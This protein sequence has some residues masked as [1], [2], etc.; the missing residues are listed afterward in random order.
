MKVSFKENNNSGKNPSKRFVPPAIPLERPEVKTFKKTDCLTLKLKSDPTNNDSQTTYELTIKFFNTGTPE[1]WLIFMRDF[2]RVLVGQNI[3]DGPAKYAMIRRLI[4][5][6]TLAVFNKAATTQGAENNAN[7]E[8]VMQAVTAH[9]F[10]Q[11][12]LNYQKRYM[13][14]FMRKPKTMSIREF[15]ARVAEM[16][17]YLTEFPPFEADQELSGEEIIDILEFA[18]PNSWQKNMVLQGFEPLDHTT[19]EFVSFCERNEF[20]EGTLDNSDSHG[21]KGKANSKNSPNDGKPR[22]KSSS[23]VTSKSNLKKRERNEKWC[24]LHQTNGHD[25]SECKVVQAQIKKMRQS[26]ESAESKTNKGNSYKKNDKTKDKNELMALVKESIKSFIKNKKQKTEKSFT[27][28]QDEEEEESDFNI[29]DI[30]DFKNMD[31]SDSDNDE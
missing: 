20:T 8:I 7:F 18:I 13:R 2:Q 12:A 23:E 5:G 19:A 29:E 10:P 1:E 17:A 27:T 11:R 9:V 14:R 15:S 21:A 26:W 24:E 6:D 3:V 22:S 31:V 4:L 28:E 16:N 30:E 25:T